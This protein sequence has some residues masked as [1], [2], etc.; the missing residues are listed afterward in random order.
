MGIIKQTYRKTKK[1][2]RKSKK[3]TKIKKDKKGK[4]HCGNCGAYVSKQVDIC[5]SLQNKNTK[6][7]KKN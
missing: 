5:L 3:T 1:K 6:N 7:L 4:S 2:V